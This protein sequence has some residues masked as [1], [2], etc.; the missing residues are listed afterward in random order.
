MKRVHERIEW[1]RTLTIV[2]DGYLLDGNL[3]FDQPDYP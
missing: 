3:H 1:E 2:E